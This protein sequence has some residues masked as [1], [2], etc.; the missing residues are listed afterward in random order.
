MPTSTNGTPN[1]INF[2]GMNAFAALDSAVA[3][4][5]R[6]RL[7]RVSIGR[8]ELERS[9]CERPYSSPVGRV[10]HASLLGQWVVLPHDRRGEDA[11]IDRPDADGVARYAIVL[12]DE[13][14]ILAKL[15]IRQIGPDRLALL[16]D[17][18]PSRLSRRQ[19]EA[20]QQLEQ[21]PS[22]RSPLANRLPLVPGSPGEV[23]LRTLRE[24]RWIV[25]DPVHERP[26]VLVVGQNRRKLE[27]EEVAMLDAERDQRGSETG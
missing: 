3:D 5:G 21:L 11:A 7:E 16:D 27:S 23:L 10:I 20:A 14:R 15:F 24:K 12:V 13:I 9:D 26:G 17:V 18:Q 19:L 2:A 25:D 4:D 1:S 22:L 8:R 6:P